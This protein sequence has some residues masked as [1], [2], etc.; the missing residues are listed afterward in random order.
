MLQRQL[1]WGKSD[2]E[3][4]SEQV[5]LMFQQL[6]L[7]RLHC[8]Q[9]LGARD[10]DYRNRKKPMLREFARDETA[11]NNSDAVLECKHETQNFCNKR[12]QE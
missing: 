7:P 10:V 2:F 5:K 4:A 11:L 6:S 8:K 9:R 12:R 1:F 3:A